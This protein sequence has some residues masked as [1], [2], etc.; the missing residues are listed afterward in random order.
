MSTREFVHRRSTVPGVL[1]LYGYA[2][3][4]LT[5]G[6]H[7]GLPSRGLTFI[8]SM[9]DPV[10]GAGTPGDWRAGRLDAFDTLLAGLH[11]SPTYIRQPI[12]QRGVQI[13]VH[14]LAAGA[15]F[16]VPAGD[17]FRSSMPAENVLGAGVAR[18][19]DRLHGIPTWPG[20]FD[21]VEDYLRRR[22]DQAS[23]A[24]HRP[25]TEIVAAW[26]RLAATGGAATVSALARESCLSERQLA[27]V[28]RRELGT[29]PR[30]LARLLRFD[31]AF[32]ALTAAVRRGRRPLL[33]DL[34]AQTGY[35]DQ[36]HLAREFRRFTE[37]SPSAF[38]SEEIGNIQAGGHRRAQ[39]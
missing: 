23:T 33:A 14:P 11:L 35:Y 19:R 26:D 16:G 10:E 34:A 29:T 22:L 18:L 2:A 39:H 13:S 1:A 28:V 17:L 4:G 9:D 7:R 31:A 25:R 5:E 20:R 12:R 24:R 6:L 8:L 27:V 38:V 36:A 30:E 32:S 3:D 21:A 37:S 15:L